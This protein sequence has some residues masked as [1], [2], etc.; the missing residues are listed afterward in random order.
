VLGTQQMVAF[1][2]SADPDAARAFYRDTLGLPLVS[3]QPYALV[4]EGEGT[5]LRV[6]KVPRH[7]PLGY[8]VLGWSVRDVRAAVE[9]LSRRGVLF[10][11]FEHLPQDEYGAW[12]APDGTQVVWFKDPD[13]NVLSLSQAP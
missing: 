5:T 13:G 2:A 10:E 1:V 7:V 6:Q 8:T 9:D 4:F 11:R 12:S 3:D